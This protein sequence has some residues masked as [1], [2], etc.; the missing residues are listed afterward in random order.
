MHA[1]S[2]VVSLFTCQI[3]TT[4]ERGRR[5]DAAKRATGSRL[6]PELRGVGQFR[7][8][9]PAFLG[10]SSVH[11]THAVAA[12]EGQAVSL[13]MQRTYQR[14]VAEHKITLENVPQ[15]SSSIVRVL[16]ELW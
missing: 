5:N 13:N 12:A 11:L 4:S 6:P 10:G 9:W 14:D 7:K 8:A 1:G 16:I 2:S 15:I 3:W